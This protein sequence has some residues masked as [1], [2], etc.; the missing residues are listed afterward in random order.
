MACGDFKFMMNSAVACFVGV[1]VPA[2]CIVQFAVG[3][4][5]TLVQYSLCSYNVLCQLK[6]GMLLA[7]GSKPE[8]ISER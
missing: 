7:F 2:I 5:K 6:Y 3:E 1:Y 4:H 8:S